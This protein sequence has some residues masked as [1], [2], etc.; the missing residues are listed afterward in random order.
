MPE[1][2]LENFPQ[3]LT[4]ASLFK[5]TKIRSMKLSEFDFTLPPE[6]IAQHPAS[7]RDLSKLMVVN[8]QENTIEHKVF[9][10]ILD[11]FDDGDVMVLNNA[12]VFPA[13]LFGKKE[14]TGAK[15]EVFLLREL[16]KDLRLW[17][18]LVDPARKIRVGNKL[19]FGEDEMVAEVIDNTTSRGRTIRFLY[20][21]SDE[22]FKK[23][24]YR[25]G[26]TPLPKYIER[27]IEADDQE[28]FQTIFA[29]VEGSIAPPTAGL[30]FTRELMMRLEI[31]GI[32]FQKVSLTLGLG[33]SRPV[34]VEDLTKHKMD[35]EHFYINEDVANKV[36]SS[37]KERKKVC[38]VGSSV[39]RALETS[40]SAFGMLNP[41][42]GWTDKFIF[43]PHEFRIANSLLTN[44]HEP[45][46]TL[47]MLTA[48]FVD[49]FD[50]MKEIY[51][52]AL[53]NDYRF[54]AYG[55]A[56]LIL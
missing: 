50:F 46:S 26:E 12:K 42:E 20:D 6:K 25:L 3:N 21:G 28:N 31:K 18:V 23:V 13:R 32:D 17:D 1:F 53:D 44:F 2:A 45:Q 56:I 9:K 5:N 54:L 22:E 48:A 27:D 16:N 4:F 52:S 39:M 35:S 19:F 51:Q 24:I 47:N 11:I 7:Y 38:A 37:L 41:G 10:D 29:E 33:S 14:K 40:V 55:D 36:N 34:E 15:I 30:H 8:R 49:D 43:P